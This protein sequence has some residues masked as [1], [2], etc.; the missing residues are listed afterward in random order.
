ML[1]SPSAFAA[2]LSW[3]SRRRNLALF[4]READ[5]AELLREAS[6]LAS[7]TLADEPSALFFACARRGRVLGPVAVLAIPLV[8]RE[9]ARVVG[10]ELDANDAELAVLRLRIVKQAIEFGELKDW[11]AARQRPLPRP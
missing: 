11:F 2:G 1:P 6:V 7:G 9:Q 5:L 3:L 8:A 4:A 10:F